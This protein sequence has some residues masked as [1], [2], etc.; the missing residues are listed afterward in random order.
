[1]EQFEPYNITI[2]VSGIVGFIF[3]AQLI[4]VDL[5]ALKGKHT[6]GYP[7]KPDHDDFLFRAVRAHSN[8][9]ES[10]GIFILFVFFG[11]LSACNSYW[12]NIFSSV[13]LIGRIAHMFFY[14]TNIKLAR[15]VSFGLSLLGLLGMF[16]V[17][18]I[19]WF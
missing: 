10:V 18:I 16:I 13:Y 1:M 4:V 9:N 3:L 7:I 15:S 6:P 5:V 8:S 11:V 17:S 2:L 14:Y 12:L 19:S